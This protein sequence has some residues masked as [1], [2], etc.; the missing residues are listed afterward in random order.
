MAI[1]DVDIDQSKAACQ[2]GEVVAEID[3]DD[4]QEARRDPRLQ[5]FLAEARAYGEQ[6][7]QAGR[8]E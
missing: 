6:L 3:L 1:V 2:P 8:S 4:F 7:E 5:A